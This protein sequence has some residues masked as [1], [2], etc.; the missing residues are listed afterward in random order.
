MIYLVCECKSGLNEDTFWI[1][2]ERE[3]KNH[4][5]INK[6]IIPQNFDEINDCIIVYST[7]GE[8]KNPYNKK[9]KAFCLAWE[10]YPE[11]KK[12]LFSNEWNDKINIT[13]ECA[14]SATEILVATDFA[15]PYYTDFGNVSK[16]ELGLD[17]EIFKPLNNK[18]EL[19]IKY[20]LPT[21]SKIGYWGGTN[22]VM[23]GFNKLIDYTNKNNNNI[24]WI[25]VWKQQQE[26]GN[27]PDYIKNKQFIKINQNQIN[28]LMNCSDF[29]LCTSLL[30]PY[31][32]TELEAMATN[33]NFVFTE[34]I[35]KDF[36]PS[37]NPRNDIFEKGWDRNT[38]KQK[39]INLFNK[40]QIK[41]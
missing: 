26:C 37:E 25:I 33:I 9:Y 20:G 14:K 29:F 40:Y 39:W 32:M 11:M 16:M 23:K 17:T 18:L 2:F 8:I 30:R 31:Y 1:W 21:D 12:M 3:F 6:P 38:V 41:Y 5:F 28:E 36:I 34:N 13:Q 22:H 24:F 19:R 27:C 4:I 35:E 15:I 7:M 10:L